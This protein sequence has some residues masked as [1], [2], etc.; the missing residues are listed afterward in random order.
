MHEQVTGEYELISSSDGVLT[1]RRRRSA[2]RSKPQALG[3]WSHVWFREYALLAKFR[4]VCPHMH[5]HL[6]THVADVLFTLPYS[7]CKSR[8]IRNGTL[9]LEVNRGKSPKQHL[10]HKGTNTFYSSRNSQVS[11]RSKDL[12]HHKYYQLS[13]GADSVL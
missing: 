2:C 12:I 11:I 3:A 9:N 7:Y 13:S 6:T 10:Q 8:D 1:A 4:Q 5:G